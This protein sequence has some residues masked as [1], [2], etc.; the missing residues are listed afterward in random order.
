VINVKK[1]NLID[2]V[3]KHTH[4]GRVEYLID[5]C[6]SAELLRQ[7]PWLLRKQGTLLLYGHGHRGQDIGI[8]NLVQFLEPTLVSPVGASGDLSPEGKPLLYERA[9]DCISTGKVTV[10]DLVTHTYSTLESVHHALSHDYQ[11]GNYVKGVLQLK[12]A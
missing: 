11:D 5:A 10:S 6:G 4:G 7:V 9:L 12:E 3:D 8:L 2:S 1:E